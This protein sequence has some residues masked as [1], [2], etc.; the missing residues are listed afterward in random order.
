M[1]IPLFKRPPCTADRFAL[2][3]SPLGVD[4]TQ[5]REDGQAPRTHRAD[6]ER[7]PTTRCCTPR[8]RGRRTVTVP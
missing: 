2:L 5:T 6:E 4:A 3:K 1:P 7:G 8:T